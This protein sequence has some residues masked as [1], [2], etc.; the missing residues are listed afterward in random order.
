MAEVDVPSCEAFDRYDS[1][2]HHSL[3]A[4]RSLARFDLR[5]DL[6]NVGHGESSKGTIGLVELST[7]AIVTLANACSIT[8]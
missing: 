2:E 7:S 8:A 6:R 4:D 1:Q 3:K 5:Q